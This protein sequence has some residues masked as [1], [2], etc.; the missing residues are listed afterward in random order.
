MYALTLNEWL[1]DAP[2]SMMA[3]TSLM[4]PN[5]IAAFNF[6]LFF[7]LQA[8]VLTLLASMFPTTARCR[9]I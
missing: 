9:V 7:E 8:S 1:A 5:W 2:C 3:L 6:K 4:V